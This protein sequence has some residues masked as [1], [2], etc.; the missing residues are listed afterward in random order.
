[1]DHLN[2]SI[3]SP[4]PGNG[5]NVVALGVVEALAQTKNRVGIF[6]P[7]LDS[8]EHFTNALLRAANCGQTREQAMGVSPSESRLDPEMSRATIVANFTET[9]AAL[10]PDA[11]VI[12]G[13]DKSNVGD[14][15][16]FAF[17]A[18]VSADLRSPILLTVSMLGRTFDDVQQ[19]IDTCTEVCENEGTSVIGVFVTDCK[20]TQADEIS[21][22]NRSSLVPVWAVPFVD[23][24][25]SKDLNAAQA[26]FESAV[27]F[28]ELLQ[29][30][31][32]PFTAP[33]T[34]YAFQYGLLGSAKEHK[35][36]IVLPESSDDRI[37][38]SAD[39]LLKRDIVDIVLLGERDEILAHARELKLDSI[40]QAQFQSMNDE[41]MLEPMI[42]KLCELR[43]KKGM[44]PEQAR[45]V[46]KDMSYFGTMMIVLG[47]ADGMVS[48]AINSTANTVR[49]AL[50]LI[51]TKPNAACVSGAFLMCFKDHVA[52]FADCA[53]NTNPDAA[54]LADIALQSCE[55]A[56]AFGL[57]PQLGMLSY[58]TLGSGRGPDVDLVEEATALVK[59][60]N[61]E[62]PVVGPVQFDAAVSPAVAS[63]KA[64]GNEVAGHVNVFAFPDLTAGNIA[65]KA[66]QRT[67][68]AVA[69]GPI[70]QGLNKP[71]NDLSRGALVQDIINT[72]A[73]TA[74]EAQ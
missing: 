67:S 15:G 19:T 8:N 59:E 51:K 22:L 64:K 66:V 54:T 70:L 10:D 65:Y 12:I 14:P 13:S 50:Q 39:Y 36:T 23:L 26:A 60:R 24:D 25:A 61:S 21:D 9:E 34:P 52:V 56:K 6:R 45:E 29:T 62:I 71:V 31:G 38:Q 46:L 35:K 73:L 37:L 27:Q 16:R 1:M 49:P 42:T 74:I 47:H 41:Q 18:A 17:N 58:S 43:A 48:G 11:M 4:E 2:V 68:G 33:T 30:L 72:I 55:T 3:I 57:D 40:E 44:T 63:I 20:D 5:R 7:A 32:Q 53:I 69:I 28:D